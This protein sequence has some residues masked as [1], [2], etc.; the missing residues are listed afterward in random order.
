MQHIHVNINDVSYHLTI[1]GQGQPLLLLHG[2]TGSA[3]N[4]ANVAGRLS[5]NYRVIVPDLIG[6]GKTDSPTDVQRY[7][8]KHIRRDLITLIERLTTP[9]IHLL[10]YSMGG[11]IAL[12]LAVHHPHAFRSLILESASPG[13]ETVEAQQARI[14]QDNA[15]ADRIE[16]HGIEAFVEEWENLALWNTQTQEMKNHLRTQRLNN[17]PIGLANSLRGF[18]TGIQPS[19]WEKLKDMTLPTLLLNGELDTK[20]VQ[21]AEQMSQL[22]PNSHKEVLKNIGHTTHLENS[23]QFCAIVLQFLGQNG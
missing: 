9:P 14:E 22:M 1:R 2:F 21:I 5:E 15:L 16:Q 18:G 10:G 4:W 20:F 12:Y 13:L 8:L 19:L 6:H 3:D 7:S 11:R 17:Q 23:E